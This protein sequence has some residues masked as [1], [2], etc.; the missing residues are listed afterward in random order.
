[1][2]MLEMFE[3]EEFET[4]QKSKQEREEMRALRDIPATCKHCGETMQ[5][6]VVLN[7]NHSEVFNGWCAKRLT[8]NGWAKPG[9]WAEGNPEQFNR[10]TEWLA[11]RGWTH[12]NEFD[13]DNWPDGYIPYWEENK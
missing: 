9:T 8:L 7:I 3:I 13:R 4:E 2:T 12:C 1:M 11:A 6:A 10:S 5:N